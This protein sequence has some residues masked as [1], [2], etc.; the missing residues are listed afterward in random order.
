MVK[1]TSEK[2]VFAAG[3][4]WGVE[5]AFRQIPGVIATTAGYTGG[6]FKDPSYEDV[7]SG[8]TGHAEAVEVEFDPL[9]VRYKRLVEAFWSIHDP[10]TLNRQGPDAGSQYRSAIFY[11][12]PRQE[13]L[14]RASLEKAQK[15][16]SKPIVTQILPA[17][18][19]WR[20]EEYHQQYWEKRGK[21]GCAV[22]H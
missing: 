22:V 9:L 3:C 13:T 7:C 1:L 16:F 11:A 2:A 8:T 20:A 21:A 17:T 6:C 10:T 18:A 14:A 19:F 4:F 12:T 5:S 15:R